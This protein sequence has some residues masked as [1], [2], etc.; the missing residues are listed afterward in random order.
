MLKLEIVTPERR[1][2]DETVDAV[3][4]PTASGEAGILPNHAPLVSALKP[5]VLSY[6]A[7]GNTERM[8]IAGGFLEVSSNKVSVLTDAAETAS[9]IDAES[10]RA[11][12]DAAERELAASA[13][14]PVEETESIRERIEESNA[15]LQLVA[16]R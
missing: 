3:T 4:I 13:L 6:T 12:R 9:E 15:R 1:V 14:S 11:V 8:A 5:G 10:A 16:G 7:Q 2:L